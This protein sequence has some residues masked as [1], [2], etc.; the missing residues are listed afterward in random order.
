MAVTFESI[1]GNH[2]YA[3]NIQ[4]ERTRLL[5]ANLANADTPGY[6][7]R[8][9]DFRAALQAAQTGGTRGRPLRMT[10]SMHIEPEGYLDGAEI[11]YRMPTQASLDG[12][13]VESQLEMAKFS[14]NSIRYL[15]SLRIIKGRLSKLVT[16]FRGE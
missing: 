14:E 3:L 10:N 2:E 11:L 7:A 1:L 8:D 13:T 9:I 12:N 6:K 4:A 15:T 16:A 5:G